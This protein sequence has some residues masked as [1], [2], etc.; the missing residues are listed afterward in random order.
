[1]LRDEKG[2]HG[3]LTV[4]LT[5][6]SMQLLQRSKQTLLSCVKR[7]S[8]STIAK[9]R[10]DCCSEKAW[11]TYKED[12]SFSTHRR[13]WSSRGAL[14]GATGFD[15]RSKRTPA[16]FTTSFP[17][18]STPTS[19]NS[20]TPCT[21]LGFADKTEHPESGQE[22]SFGSGSYRQ[23]VQRTQLTFYPGSTPIHA[24]KKCTNTCC[25]Y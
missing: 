2:R 15:C 19:T 17:T 8:P 9:E 7:G 24:F 10:Q 20:S 25:H 12:A 4:Y 22:A 18:K 21:L 3:D 5:P 13:W 16:L 11:N 23:R 6:R 1:M 14:Q